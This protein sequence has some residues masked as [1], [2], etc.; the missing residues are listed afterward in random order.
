M[1]TKCSSCGTAATRAN[2]SA[3][4]LARAARAEDARCRFC[5]D[6]KQAALR[7]GGGASAAAAAAAPA[8]APAGALKPWVPYPSSEDGKVTFRL[9]NG[10]SATFSRDVFLSLPDSMPARLLANEDLS[11]GK[12]N[13][14]FGDCSADVFRLALA[15]AEN[16]DTVNGAHIFDKRRLFRELAFLGVDLAPDRSLPDPLRKELVSAAD[17]ICGQLLATVKSD[18]DDVLIGASPFVSLLLP[19]FSAENGRDAKGVLEQL[20][21]FEAAERNAH[22]FVD[23]QPFCMWGNRLRKSSDLCMRFWCV[24]DELLDYT[25]LTLQPAGLRPVGDHRPQ[26]SQVPHTLTAFAAVVRLAC[27]SLRAVR[28]LA[29]DVPFVRNRAHEAFAQAGLNS[30]VKDSSGWNRGGSDALKSVGSMIAC[31]RLSKYSAAP[32]FIEKITSDWCSNL[33]TITEVKEHKDKDG[34]TQEKAH[35]EMLSIVL[36]KNPHVLPEVGVF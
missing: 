13:F 18:I 11:G 32:W 26:I 15:C 34:S 7:A 20:P 5:V 19:V 35:W 27:N 28:M 6:V 9:A 16:G 24:L 12:R 22:G 2:F 1:A 25:A 17:L 36:H 10:G 3:N 14:D 21:A 8:R 30:N 29:T 33:F 31:G 4:Q 23:V